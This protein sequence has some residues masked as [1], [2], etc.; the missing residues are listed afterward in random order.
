MVWRLFPVLQHLILVRPFNLFSSPLF[1]APSSC[2][3][4]L[5]ILVEQNPI[6]WYCFSRELTTHEIVSHTLS[7]EAGALTN[8]AGP[9]SLLGADDDP[10][11]AGRKSII[12]SQLEAATGARCV[13][14]SCWINPIRICT[15]S[16]KSI[17]QGKHSSNRDKSNKAVRE[18]T[19]HSYLTTQLARPFYRPVG[20]G[21]W[22]RKFC[23]NSCRVCFHFRTKFRIGQALS[24]NFILQPSKTENARGK[25][26][27][28]SGYVKEI[29]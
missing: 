19:Y 22:C 24:M 16:V 26:F 17:S 14:S 11:A 5:D 13:A 15:D 21:K 20:L 23:I 6:H 2:V 1:W 28:Q 10:L 7:S 8:P 29:R 12:T 27:D 18:K 9:P 4:C 3:W 25:L